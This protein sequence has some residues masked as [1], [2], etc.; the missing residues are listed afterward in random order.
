[1]RFS[2]GFF[3]LGSGDV[4]FPSSLVTDSPPPLNSGASL[5]LESSRVR[6]SIDAGE[7]KTVGLGS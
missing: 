7:K 1:M 2:R 4:K 3:F 5:R 6:G